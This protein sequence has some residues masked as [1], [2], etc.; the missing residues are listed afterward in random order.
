VE[1]LRDVVMLSRKIL[2]QRLVPEGEGAGAAAPEPTRP[3]KPSPLCLLRTNEGS[4]DPRQDIRNQ[5]LMMRVLAVWMR[6]APWV[7]H[8]L[9]EPHATPYAQRGPPVAAKS[10]D[11]IIPWSRAT[12]VGHAMAWISRYKDNKDTWAYDEAQSQPAPK[13]ADWHEVE[14]GQRASGDGGDSDV[15]EVDKA[16]RSAKQKPA[17]AGRGV[18]VLS[19]L[20]ALSARAILPR[21][22]SSFSS[23]EC[24]M[25]EGEVSSERAVRT[26]ASPLQAGASLHTLG[27]RGPVEEKD[28]IDSD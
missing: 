18:S 13:R 23:E 24:I 2:G 1:P 10:Q 22:P 17:G 27:Q 3:T 12:P 6:K 26:R 7:L 15:E 4:F 16:A 25:E 11:S 9:S 5:R 21:Q 8:Q 14:T 28:E 20:V 19:R